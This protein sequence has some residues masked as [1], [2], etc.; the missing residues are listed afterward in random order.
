MN[1]KISIVKIF[2]G[3]IGFLFISFITGIIVARILGPVGKG[4]ISLVLLISSLIVSIGSLNIGDSVIYF[5]NRRKIPLGKAL[6]SNYFF[7]TFS[8]LFYI[9]LLYYVWS[10]NILPWEELDN[11]MLFLLVCLFIPLTFFQMHI[12]ALFRAKQDYSAYN[13]I[14]LGRPIIYF[15]LVIFFL[16]FMKMEVKGVFLASGTATALSI[17]VGT[18]LIVRTQNFHLSLDIGYLKKAITYGLKGHIGNIFHKFNLR[19]DQLF[20]TPFWGTAM[21][22]NYSI[23]VI[24][25][26]MIMFLPDSIGI[27]LFPSLS[28]Y[29]KETARKT[30]EQSI[31]ISLLLTVLGCIAIC[32]IARPFVMIGYGERFEPAVK[33]IY[34]LLPGMVFLNISKILSKYFSGSGHPEINSFSSFISCIATLIL[35]PLLVPKYGI[36]GAAIASSIAYGLRSLIEI[37]IFKK[38]TNCI[39]NNLLLIKFKDIIVLVELFNNVFR[40]RKIAINS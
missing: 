31:R 16:V 4:E 1:N 33:A 34:F 38:M 20:I 23:A 26:E 29:N 10:L 22:G 19:I 8:S 5:V 13:I 35:C 40:K 6:F 30:A 2:F 36:N 14:L 17:I 12:L 25:S 32:I 11:H 7:I 3:K 28:R 18:A 15:I 24:I 9:A 39:L 37:F 27:V 21:L